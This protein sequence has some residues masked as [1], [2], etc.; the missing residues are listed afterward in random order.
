[1]KNSEIKR[2]ILERLKS[3]PEFDKLKFAYIYG[4]TILGERTE[5]S[6]IDICLYYD[7]NEEELH[8][9]LFKISGSFPEE[10]DVQMFQ[11]IPLYV[12]KEVFKGDLLYVKDKDFVHDL[13]RETFREYEDFEPRYRYILYGKAGM[14]VPI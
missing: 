9:L 10:Y 6:D 4:S 7:K 8:K 2:E 5:R 3:Q 1:M 13:A 14:E 12:K 11:L